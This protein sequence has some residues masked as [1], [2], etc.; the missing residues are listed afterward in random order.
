VGEDG[1]ESDKAGS[2]IVTERGKE[3]SVQIAQEQV[4]N[5][6]SAP[7]WFLLGK[8]AAQG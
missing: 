1:G 8:P 2:T 7:P 3:A 6:H 5:A 4:V